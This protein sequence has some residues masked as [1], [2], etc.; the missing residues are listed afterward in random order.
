MFD[1]FNGLP[2]HPL[3][4]HA[5]VVLVPLA[6]LMGV[7]FAIP[8][9]RAWSRLPLLITSLAALAAVLVSKESGEPFERML[10]LSGTAQDLVEE[11]SERADQ[12]VVV[13]VVFAAI[14]VAAYV[15]TRSGNASRVV[16]NVLSVALVLGSLA[17]AVQTYRV[18]DSGARAVWSSTSTAGIGSTSEGG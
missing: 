16:I 5:A 4:V 8:K 15:L 11:H 1:T 14:A 12:L 10:N 6:A 17:V 13:M 9:T 7:L 18:G 3:A 2:L